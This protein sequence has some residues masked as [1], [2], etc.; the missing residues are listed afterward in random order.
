VAEFGKLVEIGKRDFLGGGKLDMDVFLASRSYCCFYLDAEMARRQSL[1]KELLQ[2]IVQHLRMGHITPLASKKVFEASSIQQGFRHL[3]QGTHIGKIVFSMHEADGS[4]KVPANNVASPAQK[5]H[6]DTSSSFLLVGGLGGLGRAVAR[7]LVAQGARHL[8]FLSRSAGSGPEDPHTVQELQSM[9]CKVTI[10]KGSVVSKEAVSRAVSH[11]PNLKGIIQASMVLR[12]ENFVR[13]SF[14][15]W[16]QAVAPKVQGTWNLHHVTN[17]AG[18]DLDFFVLFSSMSGVTGQ[19]GQANY[20]GANTFLDSFVQ[21]RTGLGLACSALDIGAVQD[22]GHVSQDE[23]LLERMRAVSAHGITEPELMEAL[24]SAILIA[25]SSRQVVSQ[26]SDAGY[27][28]RNT[29]GLGLSTNVPL[30]TKESRA[31]W[32]KDR[33]IAVNHNNVSTSGVDIAGTTGSDGLKSFLTSAKSDLDVLRED[34]SK[35]L[36]REIGK[37]LFSFLLRS[38]DDLDTSVS[39]TQLGMDSLVGVEMRSWWRQAFGF[40]ISVLELLGMG[41]LDGLG[42]HATEGL[43]ELFGNA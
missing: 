26:S 11:A 31:F 29:I 13:M 20:A 9:G 1:V 42:T 15:D 32:R 2:A 43:L 10:I 34:S 23:A 25:R 28:D 3:Q 8:V 18:V 39:L 5:L 6:L 38:E 36:A 37:K 4:I 33:R 24:T 22:V 16:S 41:N 27:V 17:E 30:N 14:E 19:A 7:H 35:F 40:D 21:Y 12:D